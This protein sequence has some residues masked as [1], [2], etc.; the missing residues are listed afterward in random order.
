MSEIPAEV[1]TAAKAVADDIDR[2]GL[3]G[4]EFGSYGLRFEA[5]IIIARAL[6]AER[7]AATARER[8]RCAKIADERVDSDAKYPDFDGGYSSAAEDIA[9]AIRSPD[10]DRGEEDNGEG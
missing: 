4:D 8:A 6:L 2:S 5:T 3:W 10:K 9:A 7:E 1:K